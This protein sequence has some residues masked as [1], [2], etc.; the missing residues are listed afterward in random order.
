MKRRAWKT[1]V[2]RLNYQEALELYSSTRIGGNQTVTKLAHVRTRVGLVRHAFLIASAPK[3]GHRGPVVGP[4]LVAR[5]R[6]APKPVSSY[7]E[8]IIF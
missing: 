8:S 7:Y 6:H 2:L 5:F 3:C 4:A 1:I